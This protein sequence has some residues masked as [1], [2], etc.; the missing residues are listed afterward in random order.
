MSLLIGAVVTL[1]GNITTQTVSNVV[2]GKSGS[3]TF[4]Q[5]G[6]GLHTTVWDSKFKFAGGTAPTLTTTAGAVDILN[7]Q[8]RTST[9]C[10]A[11]MM[12]DVR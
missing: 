4:I 1:T 11:V 7:Y 8:C 6:A 10:F 9:F 2:V 5:D 12:N 3:I